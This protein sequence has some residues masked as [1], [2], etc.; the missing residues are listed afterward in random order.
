MQ[1]LA[2]IKQ[3]F[4]TVGRTDGGGVVQRSSIELAFGSCPFMIPSQERDKGGSAASLGELVDL[5]ILTTHKESTGILISI[6]ESIWNSKVTKSTKPI[7][8]RA[9]KPW[10]RYQQ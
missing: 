3:R 9:V 8:A 5:L 6:I 4:N 2:A 10:V 1:I 7:G